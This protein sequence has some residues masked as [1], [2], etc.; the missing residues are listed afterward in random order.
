MEVNSS[1]PDS[2]QLLPLTHFEKE[3]PIRPWIAQMQDIWPASILVSVLYY[4]VISYGQHYMKNR[5]AMDLRMPLIV[6]S[7][8]LAL[9]SVI[10]SLRV[11][12]V[13]LSSLFNNGWLFTVCSVRERFDNPTWVWLYVF[14]VSKLPELGDTIFIVLRKTKLPFLHWYHHITV[15][16]YSFYMCAYPKSGIIWYAGMNFAVHAL[17]YS[18]YTMKAMK[19]KIPRIIAMFITICQLV[20]MFLGVSV[21]ITAMNRLNK[22]EACDSSYRDI[23]YAL[24]IYGSYAILFANFFYQSYLAPAPR[25]EK[26]KKDS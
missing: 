9:F 12:T 2:A 21:Q 14:V 7:G 26:S 22:G 4:I 23:S 5:P 1:V 25:S 18:Y 13:L 16:I 10:G 17:M 19:F 6:W 8:S 24:C 3:F 11:S 20:Q 15:F